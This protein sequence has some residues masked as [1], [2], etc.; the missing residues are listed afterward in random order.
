LK[1]TSCQPERFLPITSK[2]SEEFL[3]ES[4]LPMVE[5]NRLIAIHYFGFR[6]RPTIT[7]T[8]NHT[9]INEALGNK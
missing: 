8:L 3:L 4:F 2:I 9:R 5:N 1:T 7:K 6:Q